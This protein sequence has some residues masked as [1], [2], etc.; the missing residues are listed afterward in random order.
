MAAPEGSESTKLPAPPG[1]ANQPTSGRSSTPDSSSAGTPPYV[2]T[3]VNVSPASMGDRG[4]TCELATL[5]CDG[6]PLTVDGDGA[7]G[8][9]HEVQVEG[10]Q[11]VGGRGGDRGPARERAGGRIEIER[12]VVTGNVVAPV[13]EPGEV[14]IG[15]VQ[16]A[17]G[18]H[19]RRSRRRRARRAR[20]RCGSS[21]RL[22]AGGRRRGDVVASA[23]RG[24]AQDDGNPHRR[25]GS[26][27][28]GSRTVPVA[29]TSGASA[30]EQLAA[31]LLDGG[32]ALEEDLVG[33]L[34][35][36]EVLLRQRIDEDVNV[37]VLVD[38]LDGF[39]G[40]AVAGERLG[41]REVAHLERLG[42]V[43]SLLLADIGAEV[44]RPIG[45]GHVLGGDAV[46]LEE[47]GAEGVDG[48]FGDALGILVVEREVV[49]VLGLLQG[50]G[51]GLDVGS[52]VAAPTVVGAA[53]NGDPD[54]GEDQSEKRCRASWGEPYPRRRGIPGDSVLVAF[55]ERGVGP[56]AVDRADD[57]PERGGDDVLVH[58]DAPAHGALARRGS[59]RRPRPWR[60]SRRRAACSL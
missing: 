12:E 26:S 50:L 51:E 19:R 4:P 40:G 57:G 39:V 28:H 3:V 10:P 20:R 56:V 16:R 43:P 35:V 42:G 17:I 53:G 41:D 11:R 49:L 9:A 5:V 54:E 18:R 13:A 33:L 37:D 25:R 48:P 22:V 30:P 36:A 6:R 47:V 31:L 29:A 21:D 46:L 15:D 55:H 45:L 32:E 58:A 2:T 27:V 52:G 38:A 44:L 1:R 7:G 8:E 60:R 23:A 14:R 24:D 59:R 34:R